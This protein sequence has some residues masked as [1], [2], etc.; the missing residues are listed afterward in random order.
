M[1]TTGRAALILCTE[2][3]RDDPFIV[4][5]FE[6]F[7]GKEDQNSHEDAVEEDR[8]KKCPH[9]RILSIQRFMG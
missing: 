9:D 1:K 3:N 4:R 5:A 8:Q 2:E 6:Q 7:T